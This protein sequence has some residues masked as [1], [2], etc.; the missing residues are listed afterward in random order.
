MMPVRPLVATLAGLN[1]EASDYSFREAV[2]WHKNVVR[3]FQSKGLGEPSAQEAQQITQSWIAL[4]DAIG[5]REGIPSSFVSYMLDQLA[6]SEITLLN[7]ATM[8]SEQAVAEAEGMKQ[9]LT[10][11]DND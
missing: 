9:R 11:Q 1:K 4:C 5:K 8:Q 3:T 10:E 7:T 6:Q 2:E